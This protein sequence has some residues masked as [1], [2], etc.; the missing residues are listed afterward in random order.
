MFHHT[1]LSVSCYQ[2]KANKTHRTGSE[3]S[4]LFGV[5]PKAIRDV[6]NLRSW[7]IATKPHWSEHD[8]QKY[9]NSLTNARDCSALDALSH[10][11]SPWASSTLA[12]CT[13]TATTAGSSGNPSA[14][15]L[16]QTTYE[17]A[18]SNAVGKQV[19]ISESITDS[20]ESIT[21]MDCQPQL[22]RPRHSL[23]TAIL[24][25]FADDPMNAEYC[26]ECLP[27]AKFQRAVQQRSA[28]SNLVKVSMTTSF[29][30]A[31]DVLCFIDSSYSRFRLVDDASSTEMVNCPLDRIIL[32]ACSGKLANDTATTVVVVTLQ[33]TSATAATG[34]TLYLS[35]AVTSQARVLSTTSRVPVSIH[36][37]T[38]GELLSRVLIHFLGSRATYCLDP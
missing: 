36:T 8:R 26:Q 15:L 29:E 6:W 38:R 9:K 13:S 31:K 23:R 33:P 32:R 2:A 34:I 4:Q 25:S 1:K 30:G 11:A 28:W 20:N 7:T 14:T 10:N 21:S 18:A 22:K 12:W 17:A 27:L 19:D 5:T 3:L 24:P 16:P 35:R 37:G